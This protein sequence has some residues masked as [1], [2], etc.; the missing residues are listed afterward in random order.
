MVQRCRTH[1]FATLRP[2]WGGFHFEPPQYRPTEKVVIFRHGLPG[3][4]Q[5]EA[6]EGATVAA[7]YAVPS[8]TSEGP[9]H[10][11]PVTLHRHKAGW[12]RDSPVRTHQQGNEIRRQD[13]RFA[14]D[15]AFRALRSSLPVANATPQAAIP[16]TQPTADSSSGS[17]PGL[18][19]HIFDALHRHTGVR[20][21]RI[22]H[23]VADTVG[24]PSVPPTLSPPRPAQSAGSEPTPDTPTQST[25]SSLLGQRH[26]GH[27]HR[28]HLI[29][30]LL[31]R[32]T[33][34]IKA[35]RHYCQRRVI[36]RTFGRLG[37]NRCLDHGHQRRTATPESMI[38]AAMIRLTLP[39]PADRQPI[40]EL[41]PN[42][43]QA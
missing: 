34:G 20:A 6:E 9:D 37:R 25:A 39:R 10:V 21:D 40:L 2:H 1:E 29:A 41:R 33:S 5:D 12:S 26:Y 30:A 16:S 13:D 36:E 15:S 32:R 7:R 35:S 3:M 38:S 19:R 4:R 28:D 22:R 31:M 27:H 8:D 42:R 17:G 14:L 43:N 24:V 18:G 11:G 23:T